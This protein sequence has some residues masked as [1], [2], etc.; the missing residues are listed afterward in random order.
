M[1]DKLK[2]I[3]SDIFD[4]IVTF[5]FWY[6]V[7]FIVSFSIVAGYIF[8]EFGVQAIAFAVIVMMI[9]YRKNIIGWFKK[10]E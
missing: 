7:Y 6:C 3:A 10:E 2:K 5:L 4:F 9:I 8:P 1:K